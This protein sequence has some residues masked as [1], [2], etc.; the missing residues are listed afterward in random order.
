MK[1]L[2]KGTEILVGQRGEELILAT[3]VAGLSKATGLNA[4]YVRKCLR[5]GDVVD[6][7]GWRIA[8]HDLLVS[9]RR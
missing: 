5:D 9:I 6:V 4:D 7:K 8:W 2:K 1:R 3:T